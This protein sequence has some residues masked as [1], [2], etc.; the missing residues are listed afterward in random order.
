MILARGSAVV[1]TSNNVGARLEGRWA[2]GIAALMAL[3]VR[4]I[5]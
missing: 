1:K 5:R 4:V 2:R 3:T